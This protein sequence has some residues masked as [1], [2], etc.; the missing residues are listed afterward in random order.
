MLSNKTVF[1]LTLI[2]FAFA[3]IVSC[4]DDADNI[5][6][7]IQSPTDKVE[8]KISDTTTLIIKS[9]KEPPIRSDESLLDLQDRFNLVGCINDPV[10]GKSVASFCT[11]F[12]LS[13]ANVKFGDSLVFQGLE[14]RL[15]F[16]GFYGDTFS[17]LVLN[18]YELNEIYKVSDE[19]YSNKQPNFI[20]TLLGTITVNSNQILTDTVL[21]K[22]KIIK[23]PL[24]SS[25][26]QKFLNSSGDTTL[27]SD[28]SFQRF[29]KGLYIT[30]DSNQIPA[31][32]G[33]IA[34]INM[35]N[36]N[37]YLALYYK[38]GSVDKMYSFP[39]S[40]AKVCSR[41]NIFSHDFTNANVELKN[42]INGTSFGDSLLF[43]QAA[44]GVKL[45][46]DFP[47]FTNYTLRNNIA[48]TKAELVFYVDEALSDISNYKLPARITVAC[49]DK[50][51]KITYIKDEIIAGSQ[52]NYSYFGGSLNSVK[53]T[54]SLSITNYLQD[55]LTNK[56][57]HDSNDGLYLTITNSATKANRIVFKG[58]KRQT[59]KLKLNLT[60]TNLNN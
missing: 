1:K 28:V 26:G 27:A 45:K 6:S 20:P 7:N 5:G 39:S 13:S 60:Y 46:I 18:V 14:L 43:T 50:N 56:S 24:S 57:F 35:L 58:T 2:S 19:I 22:G 36:S 29:F 33:A 38:S 32:K 53:N 21:Y 23:I 41:F 8:L 52:G 15:P 17:S 12:K 37:A 34:Y 48:L 25:L 11:Q 44:A 9:I 42:Q 30:I 10:F 40:D 49:V 59:G 31:N 47:Y 54:Y 55:I 16:A 4:T 51:G 3:I